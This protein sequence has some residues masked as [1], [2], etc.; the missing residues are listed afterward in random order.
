VFL[1][2]AS[3]KFPFEPFSFSYS[4]WL[5]QTGSQSEILGTVMEHVTLRLPFWKMG[6]QLC[7]HRGCDA[8]MTRRKNC[9]V[10]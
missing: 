8:L 6:A 10:K 9:A 4:P 3:D 5:N 7:D 2:V 1:P